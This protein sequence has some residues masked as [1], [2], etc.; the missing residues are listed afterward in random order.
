MMR[1]GRSLGTLDWDID[2][3]RLLGSGHSKVF[4]QD[5]KY[6]KDINNHLYI[7]EKAR[8]P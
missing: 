4:K 8:D 7:N 5:D 1:Y 2:V 3:I 6:M